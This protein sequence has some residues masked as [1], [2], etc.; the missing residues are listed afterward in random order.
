MNSS[1]EASAAGVVFRPDR[2]RRTAWWQAGVLALLVGLLYYGVLARLAQD[3]WTDS[4]FS[5]GVFVPLFSLF[6]LWQDRRR[7][8]SIPL[9]PS[10]LGL[11]VMAGALSLL[12]VGVLGAEFFL[13]RSSFVFLLAGL[14]IHFFG[15][16]HFRAVLFPWVFLFLMIPIPA[17]I[18]NQVTFPL[19]L[20]AS[21]ISTAMLSFLGVPV[22]R[23][24]NIIQLPAMSLEVAEACSGI[25]SLLSL[26]TLAII[27]GYFLETKI[28]RR[29][30]MLIA[31]VPI[32]VLANA[33]RVMG[34]GLVAQYWD[35]QK[36]E[37]FFHEF[38]G[39]VIFMVS[40][41]MLFLLHRALRLLD[42]L[43]PAKSH[44]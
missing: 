6:V 15:W 1:G 30:I 19:Q 23:E 13:S 4:N 29:V 41:A 25:R 38:S 31:A 42:R 43:H 17:I 20:L 26:G 11:V 2:S 22:L 14:V 16:G 3:W 21:Q 28:S 40:L 37:G 5:H 12:I 10:W 9:K 24:G 34:T 44:D 39:W 18:F 7:L 8:A 35:P 27:Y 32:A 33:F 36:A